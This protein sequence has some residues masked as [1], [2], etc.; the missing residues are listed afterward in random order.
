MKFRRSFADILENVEIIPKSLNFVAKIPEFLKNS[1]RI[2]ILKVRLVRSLADRTFQP[3]FWPFFFAL[4]GLFEAAD[5]AFTYDKPAMGGNLSLVCKFE[6]SRYGISSTIQISLKFRF[7]PHPHLQPRC[8]SSRRCPSRGGRTTGPPGTR[9]SSSGSGTTRPSLSRRSPRSP[10]PSA[11]L[12]S[13]SLLSSPLC[14][15]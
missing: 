11:A 12:R 6:R 9:R 15:F 8:G 13:S 2:T 10:R 3:R 5:A 14:F 4:V 1:D 7:N